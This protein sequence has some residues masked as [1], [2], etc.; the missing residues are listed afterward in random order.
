MLSQYLINECGFTKAKVDDEIYYRIS[1]DGMHY[2]YLCTDIDDLLF[3]VDDPVLL[4]DKLQELFKLKGFAPTQHHL[5]C[6][7]TQISDNTLYMDPSRH[8]GRIEVSYECH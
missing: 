6:D 1:N 5:D 3:A 4:L 8:I 7:I 2:E